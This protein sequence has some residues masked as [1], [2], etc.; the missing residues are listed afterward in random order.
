M[1]QKYSFRVLELARANSIEGEENESSK[2]PLSIFEVG[3]TRTIDFILLD[4]TRQNF[5][6]SHYMTAWLGKE[7]GER[8][9]KVFFATHMV[10]IYGFCL[11][12]IYIAL[13]G[14]KLKL[15][16]AND[17]RYADIQD[18]DKPFVTSINIE[19]KKDKS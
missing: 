6:Y 2:S 4:G 8:V 12:I 5:A 11:D 14:F 16:K 1:S 19:W 18:E 3:D 13:I 17:A 15:V 7:E 9:I 10:T